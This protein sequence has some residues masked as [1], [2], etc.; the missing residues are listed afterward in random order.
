MASVAEKSKHFDVDF[1]TEFADC[2]STP[3]DF[4]DKP[5]V[6]NSVEYETDAFDDVDETLVGSTVLIREEVPF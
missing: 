2:D 3:A 4:V 5:A 6:L 1:T